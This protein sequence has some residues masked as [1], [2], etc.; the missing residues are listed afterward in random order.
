[1]KRIGF[2]CEDHFFE[3]FKGKA[4]ELGVS[5]SDYIRLSLGEKMDRPK[6]NNA[7]VQ[8]AL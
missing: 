2:V 8:N 1:M 5:V 7:P 6:E 4:R 3:L